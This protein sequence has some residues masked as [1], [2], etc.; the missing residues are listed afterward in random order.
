MNPISP[1]QDNVCTIAANNEEGSWDS[2]AYHGH[3]HVENALRF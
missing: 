1:E 2:L 3:I